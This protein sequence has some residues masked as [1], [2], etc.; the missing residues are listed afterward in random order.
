[1]KTKHWLIMIVSI[2]FASPIF[3]TLHH[4]LESELLAPLSPTKLTA[5]KQISRSSSPSCDIEKLITQDSQE[6]LDE[7]KRQ[8]YHCINNL[9]DMGETLETKVFT[10]K[11][12]LAVAQQAALQSQSYQ[13]KGDLHLATLFY[14]VRIGYYVEFYNKQ[15]TYS[16]SVQVAAKKAIDSLVNNGNFFNKN[17]EHGYVLTEVMTLMDSAKLQHEYIDIATQWIKRWDRSYAE[18]AQMK[19]A[20]NSAFYL[21]Y[22]GLSYAPYKNI[23][24]QKTDLAHALGDFSLQTSLIGTQ[25]EILLTNAA[26]ELARLSSIK[27]APITPIVDDYLKK[28]FSSY[29]QIGDGGTVWLAAAEVVSFYKRCGDFNVCNYQKGLYGK[30]FTRSSPCQNNITIASQAMSTDQVLNA[31]KNLQ[32]NEIRFHSQLETNRNPVRND[33][34]TRLQVNAFKS[35]NEYEK[36][37]RLLFGIDSNNGGMYL[38]GTPSKAGNLAK[39]IAYQSPDSK[40]DHKVWNLEHEYIHYLDGRYNLF[41]SFTNPTEPV[42]WWA[43]GLAEYISKAD[44]NPDALATL[45]DGSTYTLTAIFESSYV[46]T[47]PDRIYSWGYLAVRF[48]FENHK[49]EVNKMLIKTRTGDWKG[50]KKIV[51]R[52]STQYQAEFEKWQC[53]KIDLSTGKPSVHIVSQ[54]SG[55][56]GEKIQLT[57]RSCSSNGFTPVSYLWTFSDGTVSKEATPSHSFKTGGKKTVTLRVKDKSGEQASSTTVIN[58]IGA[59]SGGGKSGGVIDP[60]VALLL[61]LGALMRWK[62]PSRFDTKLI[63]ILDKNTS[64]I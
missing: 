35:V 40:P 20:M 2:S 29:P 4:G 50:Y 34:N 59:K 8:G 38:E 14:F 46:N 49:D 42:V 21:L 1:M 53:D 7:I 48:M 62:L 54:Q 41:G 16:K 3:A 44:V 17:D 13:G 23:V 47:P 25:E 27:N 43:E 39:F 45:Q 9:Q 36:Y 18:S 37:A 55:K 60:L 57:Q 5:P 28:L 26:R 24:G 64:K 32:N 19:N 58:V 15:I 51:D 52:W 12:M 61:I 22:R 10:Q 63:G 56:V 33:L 31:C 30:V 6:L 11:H